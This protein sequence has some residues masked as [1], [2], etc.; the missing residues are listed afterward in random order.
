MKVNGVSI[1]EF[2]VKS[3]VNRMMSA[4]FKAMDIANTATD[5]GVVPESVAYRVADRL[6]Q[7]MRYEGRISIGNPYP[8][9]NW[10]Q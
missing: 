2:Q 10:K 8:T 3:C 1:T 5:S 9:W 6:I 7:K 4:P